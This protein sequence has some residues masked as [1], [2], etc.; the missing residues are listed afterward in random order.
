MSALRSRS[1]GIELFRKSPCGYN[2]VLLLKV[3]LEVFGRALP[4]DELVGGTSLAESG[5]DGVL[6]ITERSNV[7]AIARRVF[8]IRIVGD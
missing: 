4:E 5:V 3:C 1:S 2:K 8:P 7:E 6:G